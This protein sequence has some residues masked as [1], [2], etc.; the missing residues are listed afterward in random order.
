MIWEISMFLFYWILWIF[1]TIDDLKESEQ[2]FV[3][4]TILFTTIG[5]GAIFIPLMMKFIYFFSPPDMPFI[6]LSQ[7]SVT[8]LIGFFI[9]LA[10]GI[11]YH[12]AVRNYGGSSWYSS[13]KFFF[14]N[15]AIK[16][17]RRWS[18]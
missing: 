18:N 2:N 8:L 17:A 5:T 3:Q 4:I 11:L 7:L 12:F 15:K 13:Y 6:V 1:L 9:Y 16:N 14:A 10:T